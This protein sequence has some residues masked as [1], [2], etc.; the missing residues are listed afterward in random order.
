M[1]AYARREVASPQGG[2]FALGT[3]SHAYLEFDVAPGAD[4]TRLVT[5]IASLREPRT[6]MLGINLVA[7]F[8]PELWRQ[9]SPEEA[10][11]DL[12]GFDAPVVGVDGYEMPARQHD[13]ILWLSGAS[14]DVIFDA[15]RDA[16]AVLSELA[17]LVEETSSW[18]YRHDRDLTGFIDGSENPSLIEAP[19]TVLIPDGEPGG[20]AA[21]CS[22]RSGCT[23]PSHGSRSPSSARSA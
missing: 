3:A 18:P 15:A 23:T 11:A 5:A 2:I 1:T 13:A 20:A 6:T 7:G 10:P 4:G 16:I 8:R 19:D 21:S 17:V 22:S 14:Y 12:T 9:V